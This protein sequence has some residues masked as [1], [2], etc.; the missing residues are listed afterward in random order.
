VAKAFRVGCATEFRVLSGSD[1]PALLPRLDMYYF[2]R[3]GSLESWGRVW[4]GAR[5]RAR[6]LARRARMLAAGATTRP[7]VRTS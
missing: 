1:H 6:H 5:I 2:Q 7:G 3:P 4:F